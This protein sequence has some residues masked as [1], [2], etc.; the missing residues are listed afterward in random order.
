M[1]RRVSGACRGCRTPTRRFRV[2]VTGQTSAVDR[3]P[4]AAA[5]SVPSASTRLKSGPG[6]WPSSWRCAPRRV[7][8]GPVHRT[9]PSASPREDG[10]APDDQARALRLPHRRPLLEAIVDTGHGQA[11]GKV[12]S[13]HRQPAHGQ[14]AEPLWLNHVQSIDRVSDKMP[15]AVSENWIPRQ[16]SYCGT[17]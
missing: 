4:C 7:G 13:T 11:P 9:R 17:Y 10:A 1:S 3:G 8:C 6:T 15:H 14:S 5:A 2:S 12:W 16:L